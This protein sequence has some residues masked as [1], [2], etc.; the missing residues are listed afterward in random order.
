MKKIYFISAALLIVAF[1]FIIS[2]CQIEVTK[3]LYG[4]GYY[5]DMQWKSSLTKKVSAKQPIK[6][7]G[8][9]NQP[10]LTQNPSENKEQLLNSLSA[11]GDIKKNEAQVNKDRKVS[12]KNE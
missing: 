12:G 7:I 8:L 3:K 5:V 6:K 4:G 11:N 2:S 10:E 9:S 1:A